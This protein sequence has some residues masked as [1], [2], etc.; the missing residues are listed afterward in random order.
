MQR[1]RLFNISFLLITLSVLNCSSRIDRE[2]GKG[3]FI[4]KYNIGL[5]TPDSPES[6]TIT[7]TN[8]T[9]TYIRKE[10]GAIVSEKHATLSDSILITII[11]YIKQSEIFS[12]KDNY[13]DPECM[14]APG[15][16]FYIK[17]GDK[18]KLIS[19]HC[20]EVGSIRYLMAMIEKQIPDYHH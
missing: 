15:Q 11:S 4:I 13:F 5:Y 7:V 2:Y 9:L 12:L 19:I 17:L 16:E 1:L 8:S 6:E 3:Y 14:D 18:E 10:N 20:V